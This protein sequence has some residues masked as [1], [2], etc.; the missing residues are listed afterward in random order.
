MLRNPIRALLDLI[1]Q[2][3]LQIGTVTSVSDGSVKVTLPG[4]G[5][6]IARGTAEVGDKVYVRGDVVEGVAPALPIITIVV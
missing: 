4:G 1:P 2:P 6:L 5:T 3:A